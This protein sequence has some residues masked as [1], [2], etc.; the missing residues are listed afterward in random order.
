M[1]FDKSLMGRC[2]LLLVFL[3]VSSMAGAQ[4]PTVLGPVS[5]QV[6]AGGY[7]TCALNTAGSV[8]CWGQNAFGE[9]G[10]NS[11]TSSPVPV[12]VSGLASGVVAIAAGGW[13]TC[14]LTMAGGVQCWGANAYGQLGNSA[15]TNSSVP[16]AVSGLSSGVVAI[17]AGLEHTCALTT[18]G[19]VQCWGR[20][21]Y[22]QVGNNSTTNSPVPVAVSGLGSGVLA[23]GGGDNHTCALTAAGGVQ[24]WGANSNGQLGNNS[25][26]SSLVPV[27][28]SGLGSG[29]AA[30]SA[31]IF[32]TC[33]LSTAGGVRCWGANFYGQLGNNTNTNS[34]VPV[35]VSGLGSGVVAIGGGTDHTCALSTGRGVQCWGRNESGQLGN[36]SI[37]NSSVPVAVSRWG[38]GVAALAGGTYHTCALTEAGSVQCWGQ[39]AFG[40]LG[41]NTT[42]DSP[43]PVAVSGLGS[44]VAAISAGYF[45]TCGG[46]DGGG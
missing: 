44:S 26:T 13:H 1:S 18:A 22:G 11:T 17:A 31:G 25:T 10:N 15:T 43:V 39:N 32:Q 3:A 27:A 45:H 8:Q 4:S 20:N 46:R 2:A 6:A 23:I 21:G 40:E 5:T 42:T 34:P 12:A 9:L 19:G 28:V 30:I 29:V 7:H 36:N 41:N 38:S 37:T 14:A 24:C 16:V 35:A 33:A